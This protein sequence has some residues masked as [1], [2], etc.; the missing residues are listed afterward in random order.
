MQPISAS[1]RAETKAGGY[2]LEREGKET[3]PSLLVSY[4]RQNLLTQ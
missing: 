3:H 4:L 2:E 1:P